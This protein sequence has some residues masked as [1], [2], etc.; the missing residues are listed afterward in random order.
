MPSD[1]KTPGLGTDDDQTLI[2]PG[3]TAEVIGQY[4]ILQKLGE[5]GMGEVWEAEQLEPVRRRVALKVIKRGMDSAEVIARFETERQ[6]LALMDHPAIARV[7]DAGT[8]Q[9]GRPYFVMELVQGIPITTY[10]DRHRL[11]VQQRLEIFRQACDGIQHAH[12]KAIIHRDIKPSNIL[13]AEKDG[14]PVPKIIDFGVA[15]ATAQRL[16]ERTLFTELGQ[17]VG[18]PEYMSP[19]QADLTAEDIDIRTDVYS[20]GMVLYEL[21]AGVLPFDFREL[22][23]AGLAELQRAIQNDEP[24]KPSTRVSRLG[25]TSVSTAE[26]R[27]TSVGALVKSLRGDLDWIVLKALDKDRNRRYETVSSLASDIGRHLK[28]L[29]VEARPPSAAYRAKK[30]VRRHRAGVGMAVV[31]LLL[32]ATFAIGMT[33]QSVRVSRERDRA[34]SEAAKSKAVVEFLQET[35]GS[36]DPYEGLGREVTISEVL[37]HAAGAVET[38]FADEPL[39]GAAVR[40]TIGVTYTRLGRYREAESLLRASLE[41]RRRDLG[42]GHPDVAESLSQLASLR[43]AQGDYAEAESLYREALEIWQNEP[44]DVRAEIADARNGL[45]TT[46]YG[47][48][49]YAEAAELFRDAMELRREI[50]GDESEPVATSLNDLAMSL[51]R[52][53]R[54]QEAEPLYLETLA[55]RKKLYR[56]DHPNLAQTLNNTGMFYYRSGDSDT[57]EPYLEQALEMNRRLLGDRH[58]EVSTGLNN[59]ALVLVDKGEYRQAAEIFREVL[60]LDKDLLGESHPYVAGTTRSL[61]DALMRGGELEEA[62]ALLREAEERY[63]VAFDANHWQVYNSRS[64]LGACLA[65]QGQYEEAE[66][67]LLEAQSELDTHFGSEH[68]RTREARK[69]LVDLYDAWGR[70]EEAAAY[71][72]DPSS[73]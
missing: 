23:R 52:L 41:T 42:P 51:T 68:R 44:G 24:S 65:L 17:L 32:I 8:T 63:R 9:R 49:R 11:S 27:G 47:D 16:T 33:V 54:Y 40:Q 64:F 36:A 38:S 43:T 46:L 12:Q 45:G 72:A 39:T 4:R 7:F 34:E 25:E 3:R 73:S 15:K 67:L 28:H 20:L 70:P 35:L 56:E 60:E 26:I 48:G 6:A 5:G 69:R 29:P 57:A 50:F 2:G 58:P 53:G 62:E 13:V 18:T 22:R 59:I 21:L 31:S 55:T 37:E 14:I 30:F 1:P 66:D 61:G 10:C 71:R 19:E